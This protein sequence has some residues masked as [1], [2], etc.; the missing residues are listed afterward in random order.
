MILSK[1]CCF[2]QNKNFRELYFVLLKNYISLYSELSGM[3]FSRIFSRI[4][5]NIFLIKIT[6]SGKIRFWHHT[7]LQQCGTV[8]LHV[9]KHLSL[10]SRTR[11]TV[12]ER[13]LTLTSVATFGVEFYPHTATI[14]MSENNNTY[15]V[16]TGERKHRNVLEIVR[17]CQTLPSSCL[18]PSSYSCFQGS[19]TGLPELFL[20][21]CQFLLLQS[22]F[23]LEFSLS[24]LCF[25]SFPLGAC[26]DFTELFLQ[27]SK[28]LP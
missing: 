1:I 22:H 10:A 15:T 8:Y 23:F 7:I 13:S 6:T 28:T 18:L 12:S 19:L 25:L 2:K 9:K 17:I 11:K 27:I 26:K 16:F 3:V 5:F 21:I 24:H 20:S 14:V 4:H